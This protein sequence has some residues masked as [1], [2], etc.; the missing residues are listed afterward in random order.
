MLDASFFHTIPSGFRSSALLFFYKYKFP[1]GIK[2]VTYQ[3][4]INSFLYPPISIGERRHPLSI[5]ARRDNTECL[6]CCHDVTNGS[7]FYSLSAD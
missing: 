4:L 5:L 2:D 1:S 3:D 6:K 7:C